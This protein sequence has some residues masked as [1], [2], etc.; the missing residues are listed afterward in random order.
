MKRDHTHEVGTRL[1]P[2]DRDR[3]D[4]LIAAKRFLSRSDFIRRAVAEK[5]DAEEKKNSS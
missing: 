3:L 2:N 4:A 1:P 5:L